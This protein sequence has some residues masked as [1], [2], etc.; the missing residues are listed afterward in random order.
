MKSTVETLDGN[1][2]KLS[3]E[4]DEAEFDSAVDAAFKRIAKEVRT[5]G[6]RPGKAPR[7][8]LEAQLGPLIGREEAL[9]ESMPEYYTRAVIDHDVDVIDAPDIEMIAGGESGPV[10]F[11]AVVEVRPSVNA[12]G[13]DGLRVKIPSPFATDE[14]V[15]KQLD[16]LRHSTAELIAVDRE[17]GDGDHV[18]IDIEGSHDDEPVA[19]LT[20]SDY[21][22]EV[23]SG[24]VVVEIDEHLRGASAGDEVE[25][26]AV[27][28]DPDEDT[29][30]FFRISVKEVRESVLPELTDE[31]AA[32]VSEFDTAEAL[33]DSVSTRLNTLRL[34]QANRALRQNIAEALANLVTEEIPAA[35]VET[36]IRARMQDFVATVEKQGMDVSDYLDAVDKTAEGLAEEFRQPAEQAVRGDLALRRV[37]ELQNFVPDD[38]AIDEAITAM[39]HQSD[40]TAAE[41]RSNLAE[42]GQ[43]SSLRAELA[44]QAAMKWLV[45]NVELVNHDGD[46]IDRAAMEFPEDASEEE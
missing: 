25:F 35:L 1:R 41:L 4:V 36:E 11:D 2:V 8:L 19:G 40:Q 42:V 24:A 16:T 10:R 39:D 15:D 37:A 17:A 3:V 32:E 12:A 43:L 26:E 7:R 20:T 34:Q 18:T 23:G 5:P 22:Y 45:E 28:P 31:W 44:K 14:D 30:L 29:P 13:Y 33:R 27:H 21:D 38:A 9:R 46:P 6:F